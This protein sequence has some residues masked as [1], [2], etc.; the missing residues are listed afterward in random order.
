MRRFLNVLSWSLTQDECWHHFRQKVFLNL[1]KILF[2]LESFKKGATTFRIMAFSIITF[3]IIDLVVKI[4]IKDSQRNDNRQNIWLNCAIALNVFMVSVFLLNVV[5]LNDTVL[6]VLLNVI[7][8]RLI[9]L[10]VTL[11]CVDL[12]HV[13]MLSTVMLSVL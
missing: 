2:L 5:T 10:S 9:V 11:M 1:E 4:S 12:L 8:M 7:T 6:S 3:S 13:V